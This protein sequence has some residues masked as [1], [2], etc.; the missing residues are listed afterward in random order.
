M[1][2]KT[3]T[4]YSTDAEVLE[5]LA[6]KHEIAAQI[7]AQ[8]ELAKL[9]NTYTDV[10]RDAIAPETVLSAFRPR[11]PVGGCR[12]AAS[13]TRNADPARNRSATTPSYCQWLTA[14]SVIGWHF[15]SSPDIS[16]P[17]GTRTQD[18]RIKS[19]LLYRLSYASKLFIF[20]WLRRFPHFVD[21]PLHLLYT[22]QWSGRR[23]RPGR[24][25]S[26]TFWSRCHDR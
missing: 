23:H 21:F 22:L 20:K 4:G 6:P 1:I 2:K 3:K 7:L 14:C 16:E 12:C 9:I 8:R 10:L 5:R 17:A 26:N 25:H 15:Q 24:D 11:P 19:P 13:P 18:L